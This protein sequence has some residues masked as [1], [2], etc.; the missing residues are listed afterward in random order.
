MARSLYLLFGVVAYFIFFGTFLYLIGFVGDLAWLPHTV[1]RPLGTTGP[2]GDWGCTIAITTPP[3]HIDTVDVH[4]DVTVRPD[5]CYTATGP[6]TFLGQRLLP[7][8][9]GTLNP[10]FEFD[11]CFDTS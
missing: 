3:P 1:D 6:E 10:L 2:G 4:Y 7:G 5:G 11:G 8:R 9:N